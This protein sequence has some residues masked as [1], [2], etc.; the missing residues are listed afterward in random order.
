MASNDVVHPGG[1]A[2]EWE[3]DLPD[4][5]HK[6]LFKHGTTSGKRIIVVDGNEVSF[7]HYNMVSV[8][9]VLFQAL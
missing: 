8:T 6:V 7:T 4:G 2:A 1:V 9:L 5:Q 3:F